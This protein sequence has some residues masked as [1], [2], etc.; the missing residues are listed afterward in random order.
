[1]CFIVSLTDKRGNAV[2]NP[3]HIHPYHP[4]RS[5]SF[6]SELVVSPLLEKKKKKKVW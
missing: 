2:Y 1:M 5:E 4:R 6:V 3:L